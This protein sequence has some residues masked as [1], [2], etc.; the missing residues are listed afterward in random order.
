[1]KKYL[2]SSLHGCLKT[3][4]NEQAEVV[5]LDLGM[6]PEEVMTEKVHPLLGQLN[7]VLNEHNVYI[8]SNMGYYEEKDTEN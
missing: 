6:I 1:M 5:D 7:E 8:W 3:D 4:P 2:G